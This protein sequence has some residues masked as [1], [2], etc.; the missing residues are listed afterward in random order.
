MAAREE[1]LLRILDGSAQAVDC[2]RS[3]QRAMLHVLQR[4]VESATPLT[5]EKELHE[6]LWFTMAHQPVE[7]V[8]G[9]FLSA[10]HRLIRDEVL[11][12]GTSAEALIAPRDVIFRA[13]ELGA[14]SLIL[15]HNHPSGDPAPSAADLRLTQA[16]V[17]AAAPL[18]IRVHDHVIVGAQECTSMRARGLM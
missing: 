1:R 18:G 11:S 14:T 10:A 2:I 17:R 3:N 15:V 13:L 12:T 5:N 8:R 6:Y 7:T 9:L 4:R 16:L